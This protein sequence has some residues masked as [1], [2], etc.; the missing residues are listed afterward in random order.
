MGKI[1]TIKIHK[2]TKQRLDR[3]KEHNR[4]T[5]EDVLKKILFILNTVRK[6]PEKAEDIL[7]KIDSTVKRTQKYPDKYT[8]VYSKEE[9]EKEGKQ[10]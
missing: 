8:K 7:D 5:Y 1:T 9:V 6:D 10:G 2:E 4:E 3:L